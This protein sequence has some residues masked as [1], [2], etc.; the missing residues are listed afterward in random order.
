MATQADRSVEWLKCDADPAYFIDTYG[1]IDSPQADGY[2]QERFRLWPAQVQLMWR[3]LAE[4]LVIILKARQLGISWLAC[5][6]ALWLCLFRPGRVVLL[7]SKGQLEADELL[8][9]IG[10]MYVSLPEWLRNRAP[11]LV[12]QNASELAWANGS[13]VRSLPATQNAGRTFTASLVIMDESAFM[14]WAET[15]YTALKPTIDGG[16]QLIIV[17]TANG[18]RGL[19]HKLWV[20]AVKGV[21]R[22]VPLFLSWRA[23]PDRD[24]AWR[25]RVASEAISSA[26]DLQEY[27]DTP[28][29]AFQ[30]TGGERFLPS[31]S[32]WDA[33]RDSL[34]ALTRHEPMVIALDAA[35][36]NDSFGLIA[37]TRHPADHERVAVRHVQ[38]W[39]PVNGV[40]DFREPEQVLRALIASWGVACVT[41]DPFQLH[42]MM[43]RM[44]AEGIAYFR[45]F[46][47]QSQRLESDKA[48]LD[49]IVARRIAHDGN[50][51]L[52]THIEN[53]D[54]KVDA[55]SRRLRIVKR[56]QSLKIDL[57]VALSMCTYVCLQLPL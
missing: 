22:F 15:L 20:N 41:Y 19:F 14:Q 21:N 29:D 37:V 30:N 52:R 25:A 45:E 48:L 2:A 55:E 9:R 1:V 8:R 16:G 18:T 5:G 3:L 24:E 56:E 57:A 10:V 28:D 49:L 53:A 51:A 11:A 12:T 44:K 4:R 6:Y 39:K 7:F 46:P 54:R 47:Q 33:C 26:L 40:V 38:E 50:E 35:T 43:Q 32:W 23:R 42:D 27:P 36:S 34:P 31:M 17:S 13:V